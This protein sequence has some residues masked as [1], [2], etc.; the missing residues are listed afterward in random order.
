MQ[1][2]SQAKHS[3]HVGQICVHVAQDRDMYLIVL[4]SD[5]NIVVGLSANCTHWV[6]R[7]RSKEMKSFQ[8]DFDFLAS[9]HSNVCICCKDDVTADC[10]H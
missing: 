5:V 6:W 9:F 10:I 3:E 1:A 2:A 8:D 4:F 7:L